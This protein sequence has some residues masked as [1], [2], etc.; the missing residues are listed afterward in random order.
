MIGLLRTSNGYSKLKKPN[1]PVS[2]LFG[3]KE[4]Y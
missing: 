2:G 1:N 4:R 3:L